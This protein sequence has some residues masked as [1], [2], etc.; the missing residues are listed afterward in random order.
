MKIGSLK[1]G[2]LLLLVLS[3]VIPTYAQQN[4]EYTQYMYNRLSFNPAYAGTNGSFCATGLYRE[5]WMG[6]KFENSAESTPRTFLFSFDMP[7]SF[8]RG[9]LGLSV[10]NDY[11]GLNNSI[12]AKLDYAYHLYWGPGNLS[13]GVEGE[14]FNKNFAFNNATTGSSQT[15]DPLN[16]ID[17][18]AQDPLIGRD[19]ASDMLM[20]FGLGFYYQI[21]GLMYLGLSATK[22]LEAKSDIVN[23]HNARHIYLTGGY[24]YTLPANPSLRFIPSFLLTV[25][26]LSLSTSTFDLSCLAEYQRSFWLGA[27]YRFQDAFSLMGG[28]YWKD[29]RIGLSYDMTTSKLGAYKSGKS[30]GSVELFVR[31]CFK[32]TRPPKPPTIYRNTR[33]LE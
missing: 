11:I 18:S 24:E 2:F 7:V 21:P 6:L 5:Q 20:D 19:A 31:Y 8:L 23:T 15:G 29:F 17:E 3:W 27:S 30:F 22:I 4:P 28:V 33:Y 25:K 26:G 10:N 13:I 1:K 16:P 32:I 14:L 9:G 12:T